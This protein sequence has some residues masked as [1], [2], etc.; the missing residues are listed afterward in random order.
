MT[1]ISKQH[2]HGDLDPD[3]TEKLITHKAPVSSVTFFSAYLIWLCPWGKSCHVL[4]GEGD[5]V[6]LFL[7]GGYVITQ[8]KQ[9][10]VF[11]F[12]MLFLVG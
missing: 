6:S 2:K 7:K 10:N 3:T 12:E 4:E 11:I 5:E 8:Q 9:L 1:W